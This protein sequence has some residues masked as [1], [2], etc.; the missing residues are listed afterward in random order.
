MT[1]LYGQ[2]LAAQKQQFGENQAFGQGIGAGLGGIAA[3]PFGTGIG[4]WW[5]G[6]QYAN[7]LPGSKALGQGGI[8]SA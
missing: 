4:N 5:Q 6:L 1:N 2:Q 7:P 3:S 8:G